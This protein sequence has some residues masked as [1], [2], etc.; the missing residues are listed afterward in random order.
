MRLGLARRT[1]HSFIVAATCGSPPSILVPLIWRMT[2]PRQSPA[3]RCTNPASAQT[4]QHD[5][6]TC[7]ADYARMRTCRYVG[8]AFAEPDDTNATRE[9]QAHVFDAHLCTVARASLSV[10]YDVNIRIIHFSAWHDAVVLE[11][12]GSRSTTHPSCAVGSTLEPNGQ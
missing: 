3:D 2:S 9:A 12:C 11:C 5:V 6:R 10:D 4:R 1:Y 7:A 8:T